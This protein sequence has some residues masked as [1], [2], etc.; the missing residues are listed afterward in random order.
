MIHESRCGLPDAPASGRRPPR[1]GR[2]PGRAPGSTRRRPTARHD[3]ALDPIGRGTPPLSLAGP[4]HRIKLCKQGGTA[5]QANCPA[6]WVQSGSTGI[7]LIPT[8]IENDRYPPP[9][10]RE[11]SIHAPVAYPPNDG[12]QKQ[13]RLY[14]RVALKKGAGHKMSTIDGGRDQHI[15]STVRAGLPSAHVL[16]C[17][18][19][20]C[21]PPRSS[22]DGRADRP[23]TPETQR[24]G[25][26]ARPGEDSAVAI[27]RRSISWCGS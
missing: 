20:P 7:A 22:A 13:N 11:P 9:A 27:S 25:R 8:V 1:G 23:K 17:L 14:L 16:I 19:D 10:P 18:A 12:K 21:T 24:A 26:P 5:R 6:H 3:Q 4:Q 2:A 15:L